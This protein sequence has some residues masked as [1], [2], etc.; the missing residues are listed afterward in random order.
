MSA[1]RIG[2]LGYGTVGAAVHRLLD[3]GA[4]AIARVTGG[5]VEVAAA[6]VRDPSRHAAAP[7]GLPTSPASATTTRSRS[8]QR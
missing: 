4:A 2:L 8:W 3:G 1:T 6:L 5:P 7:A